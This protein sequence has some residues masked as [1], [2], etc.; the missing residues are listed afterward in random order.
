MQFPGMHMP[1]KTAAQKRAK[2]V[3][4]EQWAGKEGARIARQRAAFAEN[5]GPARAELQRLMLDRAWELLDAGEAE[6]AD[7][8][9]EFVPEAEAD[10]LLE[11]FFGDAA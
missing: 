5:L 7:A 10:A 4:F 2:T 11:E 1:D 9:L 6:A 3:A 8:L